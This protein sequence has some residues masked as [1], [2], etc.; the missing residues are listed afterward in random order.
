MFVKENE[1]RCACSGQ[2][3][4]KSGISFKGITTTVLRQIFYKAAFVKGELYY[5]K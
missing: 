1:L 2:W 5:F 3:R 4:S